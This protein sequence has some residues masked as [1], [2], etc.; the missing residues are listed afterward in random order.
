MSKIKV[1]TIVNKNDNGAPE[2]SKGATIPSGQ[3]LSS[4][5]GMN[6]TGIVTASSFVGNGSNLTGLSISTK[7]QAIAYKLILKFDEF[8]S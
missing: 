6:V 3:V 1:N 4:S 8:A 5:S 2:L 7:G